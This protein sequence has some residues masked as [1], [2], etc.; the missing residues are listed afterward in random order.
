MHAFQLAERSSKNVCWPKGIREGVYI[1]TSHAYQDYVKKDN[2][3][4][5]VVKKINKNS[6]E[7]NKVRQVSTRL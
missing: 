3:I 6:E 1:Y 2:R 7:N 5:R 4:K